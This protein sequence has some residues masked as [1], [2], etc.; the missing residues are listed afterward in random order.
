[1][2]EANKLGLSW[3]AV[4]FGEP[5]EMKLASGHKGLTAFTLTA[6]GKAGHSGY[7]E[8]G[9]SALHM[10]IPALAAL[11]DL[12]LPSS[13]K[14][15]N[16][17]LNIGKVDGGVA[18]NVI[19]AHAYAEVLV[20]IAEGSAEDMRALLTKTIQDT[21]YG[22]EIEIT[23]DAEGYGPQEMEGDV[24]GKIS[25]IRFKL[26]HGRIRTHGCLLWNRHPKFRR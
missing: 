26:T 2:R 20:R 6:H 21:P 1:M 3:E 25:H 19:A 9:K 4:V 22:S 17:T 24:A 12:K 15:G 16:S 14:L 8:L 13:K 18:H 23:W 11:E 10:L 7:P 5:T